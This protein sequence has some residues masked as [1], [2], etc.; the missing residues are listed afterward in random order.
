MG[1]VQNLA[2]R[3]VT[4]LPYDSRLALGAPVVS[5]FAMMLLLAPYP[6]GVTGLAG[7]KEAA[8]L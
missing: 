5:V 7:A 4:N 3:R 6:T 8:T 2:G 1:W